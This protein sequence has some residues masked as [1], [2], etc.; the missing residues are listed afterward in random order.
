[1]AYKSYRLVVW[2]S[3]ERDC[4]IYRLRQ[5]SDGGIL[6]LKKSYQKAYKEYCGVRDT[7]VTKNLSPKQWKKIE[8]VINSNCFWTMPLTDNRN[9][10]DGVGFLLEAFDPEAE[11]PLESNYAVVSRWS[12]EKGTEFKAICDVI[13]D[14]DTS[15]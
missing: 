5:T 7:I 12:P 8:Y 6:T 3:F 2:Y 11:N 10:L 13:R 15:K 4:W 1:M 14:L 9:G